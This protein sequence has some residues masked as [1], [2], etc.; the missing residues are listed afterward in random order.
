MSIFSAKVCSENVLEI[1]SYTC[2]LHAVLFSGAFTEHRSATV[3]HKYNILILTKIVITAFIQASNFL[4]LLHRNCNVVFNTKHLLI[5][6]VT[7]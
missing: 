6:C 2:D 5:T 3:F 7:P 4:R 1:G